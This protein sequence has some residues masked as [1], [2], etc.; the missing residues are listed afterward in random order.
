MQSI[1]QMSVLLLT[2]LAF[3]TFVTSVFMRRLQSRKN[4]A[5]MSNRIAVD[6]TARVELASTKHVIAILIAMFF[7]FARFVVNFLDV[8]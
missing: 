7:N 8:H 2:I 6:T 3:G 1:Y 5:T 4:I